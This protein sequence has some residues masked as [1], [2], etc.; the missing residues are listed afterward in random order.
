MILTDKSFCN[1]IIGKKGS[2]LLKLCRRNQGRVF[3]VHI[4]THFSILHVTPMH[5]PTRKSPIFI[6]PTSS[7]FISHDLI[8]EKGNRMSQIEVMQ[9]DD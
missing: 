7:P 9:Y 4:A 6:S 2:I 8:R 3:I 5:Q 1:K